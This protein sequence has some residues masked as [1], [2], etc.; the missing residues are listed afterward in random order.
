M[1]IDAISSTNQQ[2]FQQ[3]RTDYQ[4]LAQALNA[5]NLSAAQ[6][7]YDSLQQDQQ[8]GP[9]PPAGSQVANDFSALGQALQSGDLSGAQGAF[10]SL[11]TDM[12]SARRAHRGGGHH[13]GG[14]G[15][16]D[17]DP[18]SSSASSTDNSQKTIAN[19][20]TT[21]NA[22]G[23]VTITTT[24]TDGTTSTQTNPNPNPVVPGSP[25][26]TNSAQL[27]VLLG[28]QQQSNT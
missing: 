28:A 18:D 25:L 20:V 12:Q 8:N 14:G 5:G 9:Q 3:T 24:Y 1:P 6:K 4:A 7:A 15:G 26:A 2:Q 27:S 17:V 10:S 23:T 16:Q 13:G 21:Q 19:E 22:N 11:Q